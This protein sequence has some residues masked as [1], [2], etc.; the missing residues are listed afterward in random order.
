MWP[1]DFINTITHHQPDN[2]NYFACPLHSFAIIE[3]KGV[4]ASQF[5]QGQLSCD[6]SLVTPTQFSLGTHNTAK[7]RMISSFR[8]FS[9]A[10]NCYWLLIDKGLSHTALK[11]LQKY[12]VFSKATIEI[13][14]DLL[15]HISQGQPFTQTLPSSTLNNI[16]DQCT[17]DNMIIGQISN[18]TLNQAQ[19]LL[20]IEKACQAISRLQGLNSQALVHETALLQLQ[21]EQGLAFVSEASTDVFLAQMFNYQH[22]SAINFKKGCYTG[23][24]IVAR[25]HYKGSVKKTLYKLCSNNQTPLELGTELCIEKEDGHLKAIATIVANSTSLMEQHLLVVASDAILAQNTLYTKSAQAIN[26]SD[27]EAC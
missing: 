16:E 12:I 24:E 26:A 23:Q 2:K 5:L 10:K 11:A 20:I 8:I 25:T 18:P 4:E 22:N 3:V 14:E 9:P 7:G 15:A 6:V 21:F 19:T 1:L 17:L 27:I 13:R